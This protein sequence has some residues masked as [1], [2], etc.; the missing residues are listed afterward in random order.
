MVRFLLYIGCGLLFT[1]NSFSQNQVYR[2]EFEHFEESR[3]N[4]SDLIMT[5][6]PHSE[7]VVAYNPL[8]SKS[9]LGT[10]FNFHGNVVVVDQFN[11]LED[12]A[13]QVVL[14][15]EDGRDFFGYTPFLKA[16]LRPIQP[17]DE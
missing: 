2:I 13:I 17:W 5:E 4:G 8:N 12:G 15:R 7:V 10:K 9:G 1:L 3:G 14:R 16:I 11:T 6:L